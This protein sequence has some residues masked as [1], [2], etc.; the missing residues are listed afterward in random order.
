[1]EVL[2]SWCLYSDHKQYWSHIDNFF[3]KEECE[4]IIAYGKKQELHDAQ[5]GGGN[6]TDIRKSK[7]AFIPPAPEIHGV[8]EKL[9]DAIFLLNDRIWDFDLFSFGEHL[10]FTEYNAPGGK[11]ESHTDVIPGGPIRK[12]SVIVQLTDGTEYEGGDIEAFSCIERPM[13]L[14]RGQGTVLAFPSFLLHRVTPVTK[15]TRHSLVGWINGK[16]FR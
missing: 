10:Q 7:I 13:I 15:G 8:Y 5:I 6:D 12:L 1:M 11:Y 2:P 14:P 3:T 9:T 16:P 4:Q